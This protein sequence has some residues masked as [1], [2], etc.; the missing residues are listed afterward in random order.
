[1]MTQFGLCWGVPF[2]NPLKDK[3]WEKDLKDV[4]L[5]QHS[6]FGKLGEPHVSPPSCPSRFYFHSPFLPPSTSGLHTTPASFLSAVE[7]ST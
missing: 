6:H 5:L 3:C 4:S 1:M 7:M 2:L